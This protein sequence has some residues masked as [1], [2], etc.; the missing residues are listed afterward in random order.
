MPVIES[1]IDVNG[2]SFKANREGMLKFVADWRAV[3]QKGRDEEES[4][5]A[6]FHKR[7]QLLPRERVHLMLDR[8]SPWLEFSTLCGFKQHD[9]KDGSLAGGNM[10]AGIGYV[11]GMRCFVVASNS[12]IKGGTM[13]PW[14]VQKTLRLQEI[15]LRRSCRW[16]R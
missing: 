6:R 12:A 8:G 9:D 14:G 2:E 7:N 5:R 1:K 10:I 3:E 11:S 15:A 16:S 13:T 4:K